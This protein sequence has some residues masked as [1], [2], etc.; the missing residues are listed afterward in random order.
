MAE[1]DSIDVNATPAIGAGA[2][3]QAGIKSE[4]LEPLVRE[5]QRQFREARRLF[6]TE[7]A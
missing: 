4:M 2:W 1:I 6:L 3:K 7:S 5:T